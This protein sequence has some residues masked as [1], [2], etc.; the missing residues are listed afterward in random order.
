MNKWIITYMSTSKTRLKMKQIHDTKW[1]FKQFSC[2]SSIEKLYVSKKAKNGDFWTYFWTQKK[3]II[4]YLI[5]MNWKI[6]SQ[7]SNAHHQK[8]TKVVFLCKKN[9]IFCKFI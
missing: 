5:D 9:T 1:V 3:W 8:D 6:K 4:R 7:T 2:K